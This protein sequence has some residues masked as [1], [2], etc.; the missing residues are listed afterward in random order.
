MPRHVVVSGLRLLAP[1]RQE[2]FPDMG[3]FTKSDD[4]FVETAVDDTR[5]ASAIADLNNRRVVLFVCLILFIVSAVL[6]GIAGG[7]GFG[8]GGAV[9]VAFFMSIVFKMESDL[10]LLKVIDRLRKE[11]RLPPP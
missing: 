2:E 3:W 9:F 11:G 5:R 1:V 6:A 10:R 7:T 8:V 4:R